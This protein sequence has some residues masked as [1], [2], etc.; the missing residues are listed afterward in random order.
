[1]LLGAQDRD[2]RGFTLID[3]IVAVA[4]V[5]IALLLGAATLSH[6]PAEAHATALELQSAVVYTRSL[7][8]TN[9]DV[10]SPSG[11]GATLAV[12]P[13]AGGGST[14]EVYRGRPIAGTTV[15]PSAD[16]HFTPIRTHSKIELAGIGVT[17]ATPPFAVLVSSSGIA[18]VVQDFD[19]SAHQGRTLGAD[20]G[21]PG[22]AFTEVS[23]DSGSQLEK[24]RLSCVDVSYGADAVPRPGP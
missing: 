9:G 21:C 7:A 11:T 15:W 13:Q 19:M 8:A 20:P 5:S 3:A 17:H 23:I 24:H 4:L 12:V 18:S 16:E 10:T 1:M 14:V 2:E 22:G 6:R